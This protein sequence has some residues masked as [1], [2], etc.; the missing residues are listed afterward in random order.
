MA[1]L[2]VL[3]PQCIGPGKVSWR[4]DLPAGAGR[5]SGEPTGIEHVL[6]SGVEVV[7]A[8]ELTGNRPGRVLHPRFS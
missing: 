2:V 7:R 4:V 1:D 5:L 3:D 6:V 8:N